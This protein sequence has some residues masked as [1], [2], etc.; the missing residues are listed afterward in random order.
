MIIILSIDPTTI[1]E[2]NLTQLQKES[3]EIET[4]QIP[5]PR[6]DVF[7]ILELIYEKNSTGVKPSY[8]EVG[9]ELGISKPTSRKRIRRLIAGGYVVE[10]EKGNRKVLELTQ[11]GRNVFF[12]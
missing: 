6:E 5:R 9:A 10:I 8:T 7:D 12:K 3:S 2:E 4:Q 11:K 1:S